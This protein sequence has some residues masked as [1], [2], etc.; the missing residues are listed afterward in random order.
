MILNKVTMDFYIG[1]AST[2][3]FHARFSNHL[4]YF[5][6]SKIVKNAVKK[7]KLPCFSFIILEIF[8][9]LVDKESNKELL[10]L[11]DF[12]LK[13][14]LP[15]YNILTE[16][17]NSFGYKHTELDRI[18]MKDVYSEERREMIGKLNKG[19]IIPKE[20]ID[21]MKQSALTRKKAKFLETSRA[22]MKKNSKPIVVYNLDRTIFGKYPSI[23]EAAE[24]LQWLCAEKTIRRALKTERQI[25]KKRFIVKYQSD[26]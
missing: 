20:T 5:R 3:R 16:A 13:S 6:G 12:Y 9:K 18:K 10:D 4:I 22:N 23:T 15:N 19:K 21:K 11:E 1:S 2:N 14:L 26:K 24:S 7:Y 25:L 8:P 17:G